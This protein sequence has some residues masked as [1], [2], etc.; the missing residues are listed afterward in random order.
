MRRGPEGDNAAAF[1]FGAGARFKM[2]RRSVCGELLRVAVGVVELFSPL[3]LAKNSKAQLGGR[4]SLNFLYPP[5]QRK[6]LHSRSIQLAL[7][8]FYNSQPPTHL[9]SWVIEG[10]S[11]HTPRVITT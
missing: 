4:V 10:P 6:G 7:A 8:T 1:G 11:P 3:T 2:W 5:S 9:R